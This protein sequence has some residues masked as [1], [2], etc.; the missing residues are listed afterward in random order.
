[1]R[2]EHAKGLAAV[3]ICPIGFLCDHVE[4]LYDLDVEAA[5]VARDLGLPLVRAEA[6]NTHPRFIDALA[7]AVEDVWTRYQPGRP[8][9]VWK[10]DSHP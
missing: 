1:V 5:G 9:G 2:E 3:V 8:L 10:G 6:V 4:V 7:D